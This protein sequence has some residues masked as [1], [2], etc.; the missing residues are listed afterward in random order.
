MVRHG[1]RRSLH[2]NRPDPVPLR[3]DTAARSL[4]YKFTRKLL[5][6]TQPSLR[7]LNPVLTNQSR[8]AHL[9]LVLLALGV[10][11]AS[12]ALIQPMPVV[13]SQR[14]VLKLEAE[15]DSLRQQIGTQDKRLAGLQL[16]TLEQS[17]RIQELEEALQQREQELAQARERLQRLDARLQVLT[18]PAQAAAV[19]A[20]AESAYHVAVTQGGSAPSAESAG[21]IHRLLQT[22]TAAYEAGN[23]TAAADLGDQVI[24]RLSTDDTAQPSEG[25]PSVRFPEIPLERPV[26]F[27]V[28]MNSHLRGGPGM[29]FAPHAVLPAGTEVTG[30]ATRGQWLRIRAPKNVEGWIYRKLLAAPD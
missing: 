24:R 15:T 20:E 8:T 3:N 25:I 16:E 27:R 14:K 1:P 19:I 5:R 22:G 28:R 21:E 17:A 9:P 29:G 10:G 2:L 6:L 18:G 23:Y 26:A 4:N 30:L 7:H 13:D 11:L 12:C